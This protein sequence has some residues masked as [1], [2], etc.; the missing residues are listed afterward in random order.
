MKGVNTLIDYILDSSM[1][2]VEQVSILSPIDANQLR[3]IKFLEQCFV[4]ESLDGE[5]AEFCS[6]LAQLKDETLSAVTGK[7]LVASDTL[8]DL[9]KLRSQIRTQIEQV[10]ARIKR[11]KDVRPT[12]IAKN[13]LR[14]SSG[15]RFRWRKSSFEVKLLSQVVEEICQ[16]ICESNELTAELIDGYWDYFPVDLQESLLEWFQNL[17]EVLE[18]CD[19]TS[20]EKFNASVLRLKNSIC[21]AVEIG[22]SKSNFRFS[23]F[24]ET[25]VSCTNN[26]FSSE[27][28]LPAAHNKKYTL[29]ELVAGVTPENSHEA[30]D[31][32]SPVGE[33]LW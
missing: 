20:D 21:R 24:F 22:K 15:N 13:L 30:T 33:E 10:E 32:G 5:L 26:E 29:E 27:E 12:R 11:L 18:T 2:R 31:W 17:I 8:R 28:S 14:I 25:A 1:I 16:Q 4:S 6:D 7:L 19:T 3:Q 9:L 23:R